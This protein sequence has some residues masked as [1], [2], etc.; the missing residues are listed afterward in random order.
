M[1]R[2]LVDRGG[3]EH[4]FPRTTQTCQPNMDRFHGDIF[5]QPSGA[6]ALKLER[7]TIGII[8]SEAGAAAHRHRG[9]GAI[10]VWDNKCVFLPELF[11]DGELR[12][13]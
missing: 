9:G 13:D 4:G 11:F 3:Q 1:R 2:Q 8:K 6:N 5:L 7:Q 10:N 12:W